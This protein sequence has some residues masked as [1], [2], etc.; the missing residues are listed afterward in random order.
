VGPARATSDVQAIFRLELKELDAAAAGA[1]PKAADRETRA[2]LE[3]VRVR[4]AR[5]LDPKS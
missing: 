2:H 5:I 3:D 1:I 4:I